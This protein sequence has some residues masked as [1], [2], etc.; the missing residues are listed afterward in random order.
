MSK[1][2]M[3]RIL[4]VDDH[5]SSRMITVD[6]L[7]SLGIRQVLVAKDGQDAFNKAVQTPVH[8]VIS[9]LHMPNVDGF[10]LIQAIRS[11]PNISKTGVIIVTG[12]KDLNVVKQASTLGV[13]N[14]L[15]KPF[16]PEILQKAVESVVGKL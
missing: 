11:H 1:K 14:V 2:D 15:A 3:L 9:D 7:T 5:V 10:Q 16:A 8:I 4:V 12:K 13:N 6:T